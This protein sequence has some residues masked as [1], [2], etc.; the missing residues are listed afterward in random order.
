[1][2]TNNAF[3]LIQLGMASP[4]WESAKSNEHCAYEFSV[5]YDGL[6]SLKTAG[7]ISQNDLEAQIS[8]INNYAIKVHEKITHFRI[9]LLWDITDIFGISSVVLIKKHIFSIQCDH[10]VFISQ[11]YYVRL[12][13]NGFGLFERFAIF[14]YQCDADI[15][16]RNIINPVNGAGNYRGRFFDFWAGGLKTSRINGVKYKIVDLPAWCYTS[17]NLTVRARFFESGVLYLDAVGEISNSDIQGVQQ[18]IL[19]VVPLE[20]DFIKHP[21][22]LI[23]DIRKVINIARPARRLIGILDNNTSEVI[24]SVFVIANSKIRFIFSFQKSANPSL[25]QNWFLARSI[26]IA[27]KKIESNAISIKVARQPIK[28]KKIPSDY[29]AL[30]EEFTKLQKSYEAIISQIEKTYKEI[31]SILSVVNTG[32]FFS[33]PIRSYYNGKGIVA[34]LNNSLSLLRHDYSKRDIV[35]FSES[36]RFEFVQSNIRKLINN[37]SEP[38]FIF[39][40]KQ[41][42]FV[43]TAFGKMVQRSSENLE[44]Q[45]I[46]VILN[47]FE[48]SRIERYLNEFGSQNNIKCEF[49]DASGN[50][51][52]VLLTAE[53]IIIDG[54]KAQMV[55]VVSDSRFTGASKIHNGE[56]SESNTQYYQYVNKGVATLLWL[57]GRVVEHTEIKMAEYIKDEHNSDVQLLINGVHNVGLFLRKSL[58]QI[59]DVTQRASAGFYM[60]P[61]NFLNELQTVFYHYAQVWNRN[62]IQIQIPDNLLAARWVLSIHE[63][64]VRAFFVRILVRFITAQ[65]SSLVTFGIEN[66]DD[67]LVTFFIQVDNTNVNFYEDE[68]DFVGINILTMHDIDRILRIFGAKLLVSEES[69]ASKVSFQIPVNHYFIAD[70][71][72]TLNLSQYTVLVI[73]EN[74]FDIIAKTLEAT[75]INLVHAPYIFDVL[76]ADFAHINLVLIDFHIRQIDFV[77]LV[78]RIKNINQSVPIVGLASFIDHDHWKKSQSSKADAIISKPIDMAEMQEVFVKYLT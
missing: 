35:S 60:Y 36:I 65:T 1:M 19:Q 53:L 64:F 11:S 69:G 59:T 18:L 16:A 54:A 27:F 12:I 68:V 61:N 74:D 31:R 38:V 78:R 25:Y 57:H 73:V 5:P 20:I 72:S 23:F 58:N 71:R 24:K 49:I 44:G 50:P 13:I 75:Q 40:Q 47:A 56:I 4:Q 29:T 76:H 10:I 9:V 37:M 34:E 21:I 77:E 62:P 45:N 32:D 28:T 2:A 43:N 63:F 51:L 30:K 15:F 48:V 6:L 14:R 67:R 3:G 17:I 42:L 66:Y 8:F 7:R 55:F 26:S 52:H 70:G 33:I 41:I 22:Y 39:S 46:S